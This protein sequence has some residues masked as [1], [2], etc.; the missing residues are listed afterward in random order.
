MGLRYCEVCGAL[1]PAKEA[2]LASSAK[3]FICPRCFE[4]R[5]ALVQSGSDASMQMKSPSAL[6]KDSG[7][8]RFNCLGCKRQLKRKRVALMRRF[9]C[10]QCDLEQNLFPDGHVESLEKQP[11]P[12]DPIKFA[13]QS[14]DASEVGELFDDDDLKLEDE[15]ERAGALEEEPGDASSSSNAAAKVVKAPRSSKRIK[16][17]RR[18][19]DASG[20]GRLRARSADPESEQDSE[21]EESA[22]AEERPGR[23]WLRVLLIVLVLVPPILAA[24]LLAGTW[25]HDGFA[26]RGGLGELVERGTQ[27]VERGLQRLAHD[28]WLQPPADTTSGDTLRVGDAE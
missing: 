9:R 11:D 17:P 28:G 12:D 22:E 3:E 5:K 2:R 13:N 23:R 6:P 21:V 25:E 10:P 20:S 1:I 27:N 4:S 18:R 8:V 24:V 7:N 26:R 15:D 19:K 16:A 14:V